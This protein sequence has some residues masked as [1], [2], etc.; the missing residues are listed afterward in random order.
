MSLPYELPAGVKLWGEAVCWNTPHGKVSLKKIRQALADAGL[1]PKACKPLRIRD[2]FI[3]AAKG[4]QKERLIRLLDRKAGQMVFQLTK[5]TKEEDELVYRKEDL[6]RLDLTTGKVDADDP[7]TR[8][9]AQ[10]L[11]D[12]AVDTRTGADISGVV[13]RLFNKQGDLFPMRK[14]GGLYLVPGVKSDFCDQ[15]EKFLAL[16]GGE[17]R[18]FPVPAGTPHGDAAVDRTVADGMEALINEYHAKVEK[19]TK[20]TGTRATNRAEADLKELKF[21]LDAYAVHLEDR[22]AELAAALAAAEDTMRSRLTELAA[23]A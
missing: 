15:V 23:A 22:Q 8:L 2:A 16:L 11:F 14:S 4:M 18:R 20:D 6:L 1:D 21:K 5:E 10:T 7:A 3:R 9:L 17:L 19:F 12:E 13:Q